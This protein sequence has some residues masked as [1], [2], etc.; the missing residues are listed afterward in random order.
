MSLSFVSSLLTKSRSL[1]N[2]SMTM[3][4]KQTW[5]QFSSTQ[6]QPNYLVFPRESEGNVYDDNWSLVVDGITPTGNAYRNARTNL[7]LTRLGVKVDAQ[8]IEVKK[9]VLEGNYVVREAGD[10]PALSH[11][12]FACRLAGQQAVLTDASDLYVE[13]AGVGAL[14]SVRVGVRFTSANPAV[15][16]L[17]RSLMIPVPAR[18]CNHKARFNGWNLE[19]RFKEAS[20]EWDGEKYIHNDEPTHSER[21]QR[22]IVVLVGGTPNSDALDVQYAQN[23]G[24]VVGAT[25]SVGDNTP[26]RGVIEAVGQAAGVLIGQ[27]QA[28]GVVVPSTSVFNGKNTVVIV[29]ADDNV[30]KSAVD[31]KVL[32]GAYHNY[33]STAGV[34]ALWNGAIV[35][36]A[37][38]STGIVANGAAINIADPQNLANPA[39]QFI[40]FEKDAASASLSEEEAVKRIV[41]LTDESKA[42]LIAELVKGAK[43]SVAGSASAC[44]AAITA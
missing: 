38:D 43:I 42:P 26:V 40:F 7:L 29:G 27:E 37:A 17:A 34:S 4:H 6:S 3:M 44:A 30:V 36:A 31:K 13:D 18:K 32:Y 20:R 33:L 35:N 22:P 5:R 28:A 15:A 14:A 11:D 21:G 10:D 8:R 19:S 25:I 23:E 1:T 16:L 41:S 24:A 2:K 9:P 12:E 39:K